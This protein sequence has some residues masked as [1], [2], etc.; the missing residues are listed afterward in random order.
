M[1]HKRQK[2]FFSDCMCFLKITLQLMHANTYK[3][4]IISTADSENNKKYR[5]HNTFSFHV[6]YT[7]QKD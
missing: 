4:K 2:S 1:Q 7:E 5:L 3:K 6:F